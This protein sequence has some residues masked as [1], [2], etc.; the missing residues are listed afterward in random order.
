M[1]I[2]ALRR[3]YERRKEKYERLRDEV[4]FVLRRELESQ[5]VPL[6]E[7]TARIKSFDSFIDKARRQES[8]VPFDT[9]LDICGVRVIC[10]FLSDLQRIGEIVESRFAIHTKDDKIYAKPEDA[11]GYLSIHYVCSLPETYSG[12]R[13]DDLKGLR[14]EIQLRTIA[15]HAWATISHY[16]DYKSPNAIPS[17]L[18]KDFNALSALFYLADNHFELFFRSSQQAREVAEGKAERLTDI[19]MEEINL[20]TLSAYLR[21]RYPD[22]HHED[23]IPMSELIE[24]LHSAGYKRIGQLHAALQKSARAFQ[25]WEEKHGLMSGKKK[26]RYADDG[27]VRVSLS[28]AD[29]TYL[30]SQENIP[31]AWRKEYEKFRHLLS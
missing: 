25:S 16:L 31:E 22:R 12:P 13:Y 14:F 3:E 5:H 18:R 20:D 9:I 15:M 17:S 21:K 30:E 27:V 11:F 10:L 4:V 6:H 2:E 19:E 7:I 24:E 26:M 23:P 1:D 8:E 29:P 28:I